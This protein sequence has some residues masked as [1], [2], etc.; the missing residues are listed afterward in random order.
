MVYGKLRNWYIDCISGIST[1]CVTSKH[2]DYDS[3]ASTHLVESYRL[4]RMKMSTVQQTP[5]C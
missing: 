5:V 2:A 3:G 1:I 4:S